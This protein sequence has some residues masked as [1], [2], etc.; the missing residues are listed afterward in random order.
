[1]LKSL[2]RLTQSE[3]VSL[4]T[5]LQE[6]FEIR[7]QEEEQTEAMLDIADLV[8]KS[9][10]AGIY[11]RVLLK[12]ELLQLLF[13]NCTMEYRLELESGTHVNH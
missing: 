2:I 12:R 8:Q 4:E 5:E 1:M 3:I 7:V 10:V 9:N 13:T 11:T 6:K